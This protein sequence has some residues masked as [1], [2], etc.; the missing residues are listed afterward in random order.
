MGNLDWTQIGLLFVAL[1]ALF[2]GI[3]EFLKLLSTFLKKKEIGSAGDWM[4]KILDFLS[5]LV[6]KFGFGKPKE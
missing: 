4:I 3:A 1:L 6:A 5:D 2:R